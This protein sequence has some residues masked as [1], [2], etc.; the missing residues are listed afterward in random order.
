LPALLALIDAWPAPVLPTL[1][2]FAPASTVRWTVQLLDAAAAAGDV[3][4]CA[5]HHVRADT[6]A[7]ADGFATVV[8]TLS[9]ADGRPLAWSE[10]LVAVF[11][12]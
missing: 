6:V 9:A 3:D 7:A 10:Q 11:D 12:G 4:G 1:R 2:A 8:G 5:W